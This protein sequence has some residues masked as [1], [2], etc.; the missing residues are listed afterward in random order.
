[1]KHLNSPILLSLFGLII[2]IVITDYFELA[3]LNAFIALLCLFSSLLTVHLIARKRPSF[4]WVF[5]TLTFLF[6][7]SLGYVLHKRTLPK[8]ITNHY[9]ELD[10]KQYGT[11]FL[12]IK[13]VLKPTSYQDKYIAQVLSIGNQNTTGLLLLNI[14]K[15][16]LHT[17]ILKIGSRHHLPNTIYKLPVPRNPYQFD[18]GTYLK[19]KKI[20]R[21]LSVSFKEILLS[22][23]KGKGI[24]I[25][26]S[27]FRESLQENLKSHRFTKEQLAI[28]NALILGQR[29]GID[30][31]LSRQYAAAGMMHILAVSG[32]HIGIILIL[33]RLITRPL[34]AYKLRFIRS[35]IIITL[36]W[37]F[38]I[39]TGLSPSVL[40]AATMFSFLEASS[41]LG[42][43]KKSGNA[44]VISAF[45][46]L[47]LDPLLIYQVG[48]QLSYLAV[49]AIIWIQRWLSGLLKVKNRFL[50]IVWDTSTVTTAAQL[51]VLPLS[52]FYFHQFPGLFLLSN[53]VIIPLLGVLLSTGVLIVVLAGV[54]LL[55]ETL[56]ISFGGVIDTLNRFIGW[57]ASKEIFML[58]HVTL[59][60]FEMISFYFLIATTI[61]Y[62][63]KSN[64]SRLLLA[65]SAILICLISLSIGNIK[66]KDAQLIIFHK[67]RQ[68]L[69]GTLA[70]NQL[71]L[72]TNNAIW[73]PNNDSRI[74]SIRD[75]HKIKNI[76]TALLT[77][78]ISFNNKTLLVIDSLGVYAL[79][80]FNPDYILLTQSPNINLDRL[81]KQYPQ[82]VIV[83]DGN[84]Y[85]S[86]IE[87]WKTTCRKEKIP[88][89]STYEKGSYI[90]K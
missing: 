90:I 1:M 6:F 14:N 33:L 67:S 89:H 3:I 41:L 13:E 23:S 62:L 34:N 48:F 59:S 82:T 63:K 58:Q 55:P 32:L 52:L 83:A 51:G 81:I 76:Q 16:S 25:W 79:K 57:V 12:E 84:N 35:G 45:V 60:L 50:K 88:F 11:V 20:H 75:N 28:I 68:T 36:I 70:N 77:N 10:Q 73:K 74:Q 15:D 49:F 61:S 54:N 66:G 9:T 78:I 26:A 24:N 80:D 17:N 64:Y 4:S 7:I 47:L 22:K 18:Y 29:Q 19:R 38:A 56:V 53:I 85:K 5:T 39:L 40:R 69:I 86:D 27:R 42:S 37:G 65:L 21:Q 31:Q 30:T 43:K 8:N 46:L 44:L 2:G 71:H 72:K 87:R